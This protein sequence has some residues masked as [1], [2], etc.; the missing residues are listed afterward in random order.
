MIDNTETSKNTIETSTSI[1]LNIDIETRAITSSPKGNNVSISSKNRIDLE[2][3]RKLRQLRRLH[4]NNYSE[5]KSTRSNKKVLLTPDEEIKYSRR[6]VIL[7]KLERYTIDYEYPNLI[8]RRGKSK[9]KK[10]EINCELPFEEYCIQRLKE[11]KVSDI[12]TYNLS[13]EDNFIDIESLKIEGIQSREILISSNY[14]LV[15]SISKNYFNKSRQKISLSDLFQEGLI[16]LIDGLERFNPEKGY[17]IST[18]TTHWIKQ[19]VLRG[20]DYQANTIRIP[21]HV[22]EVISKLNKGRNE[23]FLKYSK[24]PDSITLIEYVKD[25]NPKINL[26]T[27]KYRLYLDRSRNVLSLDSLYVSEGPDYYCVNDFVQSNQNVNSGEDEIEENNLINQVCLSEDIKKVL[28]FLDEKERELIK[29]KFSLEENSQEFDNR[30][31][32]VKTIKEIAQHLNIG[33][34]E[35]KKID[36]SAR[37]KLRRPEIYNYLIDY[38]IDDDF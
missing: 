15:M 7:K 23:Y 24:Y 2:A 25:K 12:A 18:Y 16:G 37:K 5:G 9:L 29:F 11:D 4:I 20:I 35:V 28:S 33:K 22:Q 38:A 31:C 10:S 14:R 36:F 26:D 21:V 1:G 13:Y 3:E 19:A 17:R 30:N 27:D 6:L 32:K 8:K 34:E